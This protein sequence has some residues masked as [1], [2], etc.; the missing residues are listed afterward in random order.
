V[1]G[2]TAVVGAEAVVGAGDN[3]YTG[4]AYIY[5]KGHSGWPIVPVASLADPT[6]SSYNLFGITVAVSGQT[7]VVGANGTNPHKGA[8]YICVRSASVWPSTPTLSLTDPNNAYGDAFGRSVAVSGNTLVVGAPGIPNAQGL[9][10]TYIYAES[11]LG[12][13]TTPSATV[14]DPAHTAGDDFGV[15]VAAS[16]GVVGMGANGTDS[17]AGAA[18]IFRSKGE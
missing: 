4:A 18:Y 2:D 8:A 16:G 6:D 10:S 11:A 13:L 5:V 12:W 17:S 15:S 3:L 9:G 7:V 14:V 1:S